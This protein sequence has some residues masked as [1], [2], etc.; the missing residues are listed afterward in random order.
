[1]SAIHRLFALPARLALALALSVATSAIGAEPIAPHP[2]N[3]R[4]FLF[5]GEPVFLIT[6]GEHYGALLN[7]DFAH[8]P[9]LDELKARQFNLTRLFSGT[10]REVP[11]SFQIRA[12]NLA[13]EPASYVAPWAR[14]REPG[15]VDGGNKFDLARW[16]PA[17]FDRMNAFV[18]GAAARGIVVEFVLFCPFY[19]ENLWE[20]NPMNAR[21]NVNHVGTMPRLQGIHAEASGDVGDPRGNRAQTRDRVAPIRQRLFR[22]LQ[23]ALFRRRIS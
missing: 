1:M 15:A 14:T 3:P 12:N 11:G 5:R 7:R 17:Y 20:V 19:E 23:R 16:A 4:Y 22:D 2:E 6:S 9:Y 18:S 10:Y 8:A 13:P 21:N